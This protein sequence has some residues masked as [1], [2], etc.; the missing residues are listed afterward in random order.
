MVD[1]VVERSRKVAVGI[2]LGIVGSTHVGGRNERS[3]AY[4][5]GR[6]ST[7]LLV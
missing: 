4:D 5:S 7:K 2:V 3:E 1:I 6:R